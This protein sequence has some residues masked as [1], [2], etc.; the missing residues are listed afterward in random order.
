MDLIEHALADEKTST[1]QVPH[2][3]SVGRQ[4]SKLVA[5]FGLMICVSRR[6]EEQLLFGDQLPHSSSC[7]DP[8]CIRVDNSPL[9][10]LSNLL[11]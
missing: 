3:Q 10:T 1:I 5:D 4:K 2:H 9:G 6:T 8:E 11:D 7:E